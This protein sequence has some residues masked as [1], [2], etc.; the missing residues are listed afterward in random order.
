MTH[1]LAG[2][3]S[4]P[5]M[6]IDL[7]KLKEDYESGFPDMND[8]GQRIRFGTSGHRGTP[9]NTSFTQAH[10]RAIVQV[11]V[12]YRRKTGA[13]D[14]L[15]LGKDTHAVSDLAQQTAL[16]V[17]AGNGVRTVLQEKNGVT[18]TPVISH[19]IINSNRSGGAN[20][21][22]GVIITSSHNPPSDGGIKYNPPY[23]GP[24]D[25]D[26]TGWMEKR[27]NE[28]LENGNRDV[29]WLPV[30]RDHLPEFITETDFSADYIDDLKNIIDLDAIREAKIKIGVDPLG[31][32]SV[33]Y[34]SAI[35][36]K[37]DLDLTVINDK[38]DPT[39]SFIPIDHDGKIRMDCSSPYPMKNLVAH[40]DEFDLAFGND[41]DSD[42]HGI[43]VPKL[44]LLN[45]NH[46]LAVAINYLVQSRNWS[47][48]AGI[49]KTLVS[50]SMIDRVV[51][52]LGKRLVEVPVGFKW[53]GPG[54][55]T[56]T[57]VFGGEESA[58]ASFLR[59]DGT[60][61]S[62]D[63]DGIIMNL[64]AAEII[65]K[66][67]KNPG[68][69]YQELEKEFGSPVYQRVDQPTT[70]EEKTRFKDL[71][72]DKV[73][74]EFLAGEPIIARL[75]NAPGNNAPIGG[76]KIA[77]ENGWFAARPSGT[78]NIYKIYAESFIG[79]EHLD[80]ILEEARTIVSNALNN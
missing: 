32:A 9:F 66:T 3:L 78:E 15:Y 58:G 39:F 27:A 56:G 41:P 5:D 31:G 17:L 36:Q 19:V 42:R 21:S 76:L 1:K 63:K 53:F 64:L 59:K 80:R 11:I 62:T 77:T 67:G 68:E 29:K 20:Y 55:F 74:S 49:G 79:R 69:L 25:T 51:N 47:P 46:Y 71:T 7:E 38:I 28:Y 4:S 2:T 30:N 57:L 48:E 50:S 8:L 16:E 34:W 75:T 35:A 37:Y 54:L 22:D 52:A 72:P 6:L 61:W 65:A 60:A 73:K 18:P 40:K 33:D 14:V 26:I 10:V 70:P 45:P 12:D 13:P 23:G 24:A 44:G 43:V